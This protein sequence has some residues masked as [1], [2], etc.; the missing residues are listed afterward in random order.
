MT[1][2]RVQAAAKACLPDHRGGY[3]HLMRA[4]RPRPMVI[5]ASYRS[6]R[7]SEHVAIAR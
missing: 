6:A 1:T 3:L 4:D 7:V 2:E 5:V